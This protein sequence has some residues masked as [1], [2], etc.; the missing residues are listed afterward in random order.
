MRGSFLAFS[1][2]GEG[3]P[4]TSI[5]QNYAGNYGESGGDGPRTMLSWA[6][7]SHTGHAASK[8][9]RGFRRLKPVDFGLGVGSVTYLPTIQFLCSVLQYFSP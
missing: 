6:R 1:D 3:C 7:H 5:Q 2:T 8:C 4:V 9:H